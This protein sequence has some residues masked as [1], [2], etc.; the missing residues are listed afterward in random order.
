MDPNSLINLP[1]TPQ[2]MAGELTWEKIA[3]LIAF[4]G[5]LVA[6]LKKIPFMAKHT[7][8][9]PILD[10]GLAIL[11]CF[12]VQIAYPIYSGLLI[13]LVIVGGYAGIKRTYNKFVGRNEY[14]K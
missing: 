8:W 2:Q 13:G 10:F 5:V 4:I 1:L 6:R 11:L 12:A 14:P 3:V 9:L 7:D